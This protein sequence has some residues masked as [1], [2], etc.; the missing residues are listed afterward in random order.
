MK[1]S[2]RA[3][4]TPESPIR[5]LYPKSLKAKKRGIKILN[6]NIGQPDLETPDLIKKELSKFKKDLVYEPSQGAPELTKAWEKYY[7]DQKLPI[8]Q[9]DILTTT[10]GSEAILFALQAI[11]DPNDEIIV[12]EPFYANYKSFATQSAV[13]LVPVTLKIQNNFHL[14]KKEEIEKKITKKTKAILINS[15]CNPTGAVYTKSE[16]QKI[17]DLAKKHNLFII[18]DEVY[19]EFVFDNAETDHG[20]FISMMSFP[21]IQQQLILIDSVSKKLSACGARIG[22]LVSKNKDIMATT[23]KFAQA[24]L[25]S[26][27]IEQYLLTPILKNSKPYVKKLNQEYQKRRNVVFDGLKQIKGITC[28]KP[29]GAF[30]IIAKLPINNA[31]KFC[32]WLLDKF[33]YKGYTLMLSPAKDFYASKNLGTKEIRIAYVLNCQKLKKAMKILEKAINTYP[34]QL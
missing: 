15:P 8:K 33:D 18:S 23:L 3:Q 31:E 30:Y 4:K 13:K 24:R 32:A 16:L 22:C 6:L 9:Q 28:L 29:E 11:A 34:T 2:K 1:L 21:K 25:S 19:N 17:A 20:L 10:G 27:S 7:K 26:P 14:P 12:F 5:K